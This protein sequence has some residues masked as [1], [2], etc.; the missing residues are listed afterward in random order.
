MI[1][2]ASFKCD[3]FDKVGLTYGMQIF[4]TGINLVIFQVEEK[5]PEYISMLNCTMSQSS[6]DTESKT[7]CSFLQKKTQLDF[8]SSQ[9]EVI[10]PQ[11]GY[12]PPAA[13]DNCV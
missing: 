5:N 4:C 12:D 7:L 6:K 9:S 13:K 1:K 8:K 10:N 3:R 11:A 2:T